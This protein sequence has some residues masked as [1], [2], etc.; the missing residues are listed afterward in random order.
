M[1]RRM[2]HSVKRAK[3]KIEQFRMTV[4]KDLRAVVGLSE[5]TATLNTTDPLV[6]AHKRAILVAEHKAEIIRLRESN[7]RR[8]ALDGV[9]HLET[10]FA[11]LAAMRGSLD[12]AIREQLALLASFTCDSWAG[13]RENDDL[14]WWGEFLVRRPEPE[15]EI[16]PSLDTEADRARF[17][18]REEILEGRGIADGLVHQELAGVLLDR[19]TF[20][21]IW[22]VVSYMQSIEPRL[23]L[24]RDDVY[25]AVAEA[26]LRRLSEHRFA[27]WP[28]HVR[29]ALAPIATPL[30]PSPA[31]PPIVSA[32]SSQHVVHGTHSGLW[33]KRLTEALSYWRMQR[34]PRPSAVTETTRAVARFV[35]SFG[36]LLVGDMTREQVVE[37]RDLVADMPPQTELSRLAQ[38]GRTFRDVVEEAREVRRKWEEGDRR[39]PEPNRPAPGSVKK[40]IGALSQILGK[41]VTDSGTGN[42][43]AAKVEIA[44]Y[45]KKRKG[46]KVQRL[47]LT[48]AMMQTLFDSPLFT[49]CAGQSDAARTR[50]GSHIFQDEL[51]WSFLFGAVG[52]PRLGEIGQL[53]VADV[54]QC[55][56]RR[57]YGDEFDGSCT[58]VHIT[59]SGADQH[60]K[61]AESERYVVIHDRLIELGFLSF[62]ETRRASGKARLF[63]LEPGEDGNFVKELSRRLNRYVDRVVTADPRYVFHSMRHEFTDRAELSSMP[64]RVANSIKGHANPTVADNYGLVSILSQYVHLKTLNVSFI[65]WPRLI[66]AANFT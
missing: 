61:N 40:D 47:S 10:A 49:G 3:S 38:A 44:G 12:A 50:P 45:S 16:V 36:D 41:V 62:V 8:A 48:P 57:T 27:N 59:G 14:Q 2:S 11:R 33:A 55:D 63:D 66:A 18:L 5:W 7:H 29:D 43:V 35:A 23:D 31:A 1:G 58:F 22:F 39:S 25:D 53:A 51:Y 24:G 42:N 17:R 15:P 46:Q 37:F 19:R 54:H 21:P 4:P 6:A 32:A 52:G 65:D 26:Y 20:R 30:S 60:V 34:R 56:L 13:T 28:M 9:A 64:A